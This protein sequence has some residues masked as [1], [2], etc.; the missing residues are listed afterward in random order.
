M[1]KKQLLL[2]LLRHKEINTIYKGKI[3][4]ISINILKHIFKNIKRLNKQLI[5]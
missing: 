2:Y 5:N 1:E 3:K 4:L